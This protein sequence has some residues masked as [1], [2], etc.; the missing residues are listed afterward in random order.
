MNISLLK[1]AVTVLRCGHEKDFYGVGPFEMHLNPQ[2]VTFPFEP[3]CQSVYVGYHYGD[4]LV[5]VIV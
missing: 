1:L 5:V 2:A 3:F 4:V